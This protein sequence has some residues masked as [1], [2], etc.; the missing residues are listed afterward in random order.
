MDSINTNDKFKVYV[1]LTKNTTSDG[2]VKLNEDGTLDIQGIASTSNVDLQKDIM[3][4]SAIESMK[5]QLLNKGKNLHGDHQYGLNGVLGSITEVLD[6]NDNELHIGARILS[7][8]APEI[9]EMLDIGVQL[10]FSIGGKPTSFNRNDVGGLSVKDLNLY[11]ISLT[12][13]PANMDTLGTVTAKSGI[14]EGTCFQGVCNEIL[15]NMQSMED[16][17]MTYNNQVTDQPKNEDIDAKIKSAIDELWSEKEQGLIDSITSQIEQ[18]VK[19]IVKEEIEG[20]SKDEKPEDKQDDGEADEV[21]KSIDMDKFAE[22]MQKSMSQSMEKTFGEFK[23]QFF[24]SV[25][26]NRNPQPKVDLNKTGDINGDAAGIKKT[27]TTEE[28]SKM[29]LERQRNVNPIMN[30]ISQNL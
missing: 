9:K 28:T 19:D 27:F 18:K 21:S 16:N 8:H 26:E 20:K 22:Q 29:L 25:D 15:K 11:E 1:P 12:P 17:K 4:P 24:K 7:K 30:A 2:G 13:F 10:G 3:L 14:V 23:K 5:R 6:S